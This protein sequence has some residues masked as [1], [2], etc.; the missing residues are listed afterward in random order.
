MTDA[1]VPLKRVQFGIIGAGRVAR[2][3]LAPAIHSARN[4]TL[5]AAASRD[6]ARATALLPLVSHDSYS[7]L[8]EDP[9]VDAVCVATHNGLHRELAIA[10]MR[11]GKHVICEKPLGLDAAECAE[12]LAVSRE[13]GRVL[14]E[15]FMYRYHPQIDALQRLLAS[16]AIGELR[17][18]EASFCFRLADDEPSRLHAEWGGGA[19]MDVGC[20]CV[21]AARLFLGNTPSQVM[22]TATFDT[23]HDVDRTLHGVLGWDDGRHATISCSFDGG[24]HQRLAL[25]GTEGVLELHQPFKTT[26]IAG[27]AVVSPRVTL[28]TRRG[29]EQFTADPVNAYQLE[30]ED[31]ARAVAQGTPPLLGPDEGVLNARIIDRLLQSARS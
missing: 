21:N 27:V 25:V 26:D 2:N 6:I 13:T 11:A 10:A 30:M 16:G 14:V 31:F 28:R 7:A 22:A 18:L 23:V 8:L 4:A 3:R 24:L 15:A 1:T 5:Y 19:L 12:M 17:H 20:Y 29:E 9:A